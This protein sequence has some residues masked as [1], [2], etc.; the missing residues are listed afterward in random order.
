[1]AEK[2]KEVAEKAIGTSGA[3]LKD[4]LVELLDVIKEAEV[5]DYVK[6]LKE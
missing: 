3:G 1:M 4:V 6:V 2:I 5:S